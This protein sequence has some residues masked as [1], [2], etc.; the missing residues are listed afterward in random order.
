M[1]KTASVP[2]FL[3]KTLLIDN[4]KN[5]ANVF[6]ECEQERLSHSEVPK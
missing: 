5:P 6:T 1:L 2:V 3:A 4:Q